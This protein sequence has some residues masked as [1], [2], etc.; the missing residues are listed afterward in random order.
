V[1]VFGAEFTGSAPAK[2]QIKR[3]LKNT[4]MMIDFLI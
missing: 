2:E 3:L 4:G 1:V